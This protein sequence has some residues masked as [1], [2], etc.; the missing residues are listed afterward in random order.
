MNIILEMILNERLFPD[1]GNSM[2]NKQTRL[3]P[4]FFQEILL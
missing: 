1:A 4:K 3:N 2:T